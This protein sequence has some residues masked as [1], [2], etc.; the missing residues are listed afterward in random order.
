MSSPQ[1]PP[2]TDITATESDPVTPDQG[3]T[4]R[5][6]W[7]DTDGARPADTRPHPN[8]IWW[9]G[10]LIAATLVVIAIVIALWV[11]RTLPTTPIPVPSKSVV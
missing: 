2:T 9:V 3:G 11:T 4:P 10:F 6:A 5:R 8:R 7:V 1:F